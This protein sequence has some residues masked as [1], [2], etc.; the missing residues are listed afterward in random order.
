[1]EYKKVS[2]FESRGGL[3]STGV[4]IH[5][6]LDHPMTDAEQSICSDFAEKIVK[7]LQT[8]RQRVDP[9][10]IKH[11]REVKARLISCFPVNMLIYVEEIPNG[12][13]S[14]PC[15]IHLP[16]LR[17]TTTRGRIIIGWRKRV[18]EISWPDSDEKCSAED[19]FPDEQTTKLGRLIHAWGYDKAEQYLA[20]LLAPVGV[21]PMLTTIP[22][23]ET[24]S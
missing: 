19:L 20:K 16:W 5:L 11:G 2:S 3:G 17:V 18:I 9:E 21:Y 6:A 7:S 8:E 12:Y 24:T 22:V 13:C 10:T 15:C 14:Q 23:P 4:Q 1:M